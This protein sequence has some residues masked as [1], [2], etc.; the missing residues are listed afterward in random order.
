VQRLF[1]GIL[2]WASLL[3]VAIAAPVEQIVGGIDAMVFVCTPI[4]A[5]SA[6]AGLD[7]LERAREQRKLDLPKIRTTDGYRTVYNAE[8]N[9]LLAQAPKERLAT[10]Q[11]AW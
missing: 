5:K 11:S 6:R 8:V 10:C 4:D 3:P 9:R 7:I 1:V 2:A